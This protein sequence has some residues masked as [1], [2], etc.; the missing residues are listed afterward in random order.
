MKKKPVIVWPIYSASGKRLLKD[1]SIDG[2]PFREI[3][4]RCQRET[5]AWFKHKLKTDEKFRKLMSGE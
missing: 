2:V 3:W 1:G 4:K 5:N